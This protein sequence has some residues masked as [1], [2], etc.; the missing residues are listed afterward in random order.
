MNLRRTGVII[1][2]GIACATIFAFAQQGMLQPLAPPLAVTA[3][4]SFVSFAVNLCLR[5]SDSPH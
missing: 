2:A 1:L 3:L 5:I 4:A